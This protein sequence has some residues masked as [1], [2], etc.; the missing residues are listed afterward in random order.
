MHKEVWK[1][2]FHLRTDN[3]NFIAEISAACTV[4][5][6]LPQDSECTLWI[7]YTATIHAL[8]TEP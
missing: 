7:D 1:G 3:N 5:N 4:I 2:G 8:Q 6:A